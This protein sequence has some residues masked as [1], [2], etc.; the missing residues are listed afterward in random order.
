MDHLVLS[1][2]EDLLEQMAADVYLKSTRAKNA[3]KTLRKKLGIPGSCRVSFG[4]YNS[5]S[6]IDFFV[7]ALKKAINLLR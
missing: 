7:D 5:L 3:A 1:A 2:L 4:I 6:E